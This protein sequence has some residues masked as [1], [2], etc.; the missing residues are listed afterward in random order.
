MSVEYIPDKELLRKNQIFIA[1]LKLKETK[2]KSK[3]ET[4]DD[5]RIEYFFFDPNTIEISELRTLGFKERIIAN[6]IK[7]REKGGSFIHPEDLK[8]IYGLSDKKYLAVEK[9]IKIES[10]EFNKVIPEE[11]QVSLIIDDIKE[12]YE[13]NSLTYKDLILLTDGNAKLTGRILNYKNLLGGYY[14]VK[15]LLEVYEMNDS[16]YKSL[17]LAI[18]VD[19][20]HIETLSINISSYSDLLRHPYFEKFHVDIIM[21][22]REY[23]NSEIDLK[24]FISNQILPDSITRKIRPYLRN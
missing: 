15:Q 3:I 16:I 19:T 11:K 5:L 6:I 4:L 10:K 22:Y 13:L 21:K 24:E 23:K 2:L 9:W 7:Y 20:L 18:T 14:S 8:V 12:D 1:S 17:D